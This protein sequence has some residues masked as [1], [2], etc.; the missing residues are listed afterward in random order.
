MQASEKPAQE[1]TFERHGVVWIELAI[2][3]CSCDMATTWAASTER[4][5]AR[6]GFPNVSQAASSSSRFCGFIDTA[7]RG[8]ILNKGGAAVVDQPGKLPT[9]KAVRQEGDTFDRTRR[10]ADRGINWV[11]RTS[12]RAD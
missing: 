10:G 1:R 6:S 3:L 4:V 2:R 9:S 12:P 5:G 7:S 11:C 8:A